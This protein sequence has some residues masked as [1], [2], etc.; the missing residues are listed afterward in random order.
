[1][2]SGS[3]AK[4]GREAYSTPPGQFKWRFEEKSQLC[5]TG[6]GPKPWCLWGTEP[7]PIP[8]A[9]VSPVFF[10]PCALSE[11]TTLHIVTI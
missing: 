3:T 11:H 7:R 6:P 5:R 4:K 1:M 2:A 10:A 9:S 8:T